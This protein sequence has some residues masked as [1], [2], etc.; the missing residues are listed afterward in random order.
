MLALRTTPLNDKSLPS[1]RTLRTNLP[2]I[3]HDRIMKKCQAVKN[4]N[5]NKELE[6]LKIND[7]V[8]IRFQ[9][10]WNRK[11]KVIKK[12]EESRSYLIETEKGNY[13]RR[14]RRHL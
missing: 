3:K 12:L 1:K 5:K 14:N 9:G 13:L 11:R 4:V 10:N 7:T 6:I 2:N 8:R